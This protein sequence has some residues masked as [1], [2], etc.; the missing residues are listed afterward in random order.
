M[1]TTGTFEALFTL[2]VDMLCVAG[3][4]GYFKRL[5]PAWN[6]TLG[7]TE[8]ELTAKPY[9]DFSVPVQG[10]HVQMAGVDS[11]AGTS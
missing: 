8:A 11:H 9:L 4:D 1:T 5:N 6:R 7:F 2:S 10:R 3:Y